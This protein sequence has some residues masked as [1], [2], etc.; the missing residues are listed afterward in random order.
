MEFKPFFAGLIS[1]LISSIGFAQICGTDYFLE[2]EYAKNPSFQNTVEQNWMIS[3]LPI[4]QTEG[5][6]AVSIIPVVF[7]VFH[8]N[9]KGN[10]SYAQ[11][12]SAMKMINNDFRRTNPDTGNTRAIFAPF[13]ADSEV[14]FRLARIDPDGNCTNGVVRINNGNA[15]NNAGNNVKSLSYW[16]SNQYFNIWVVNTIES[17][18]VN[19]I[20]LGYA[21]FPG[22]GSWNTYGVVIR[23]DRVGSIGTAAAQD[24]TLTHEIGH[25]LNLLHTFQSGCGSNCESSGDR[26]CDTPPVNSSTQPCATSQNQCSNDTQG[27][28]VYTTDVFDQIENYMSYNDCQNMFSLGQKSRMQNTL[29]NVSTLS[30]LTSSTN[31]QNT[32][33]NLNIT[34]ICNVD[35]ESATQVACVGEPLQFTDLSYFNP[36]SF[37]W[38]FPGGY[39]ATSNN[40]N[41]QV[42]YTTPGKYAVKLTVRDSLNMSMSETKT[43]YITV[44]S[45]EGTTAP[46][47][48]SFE[49]ANPLDSM[50]WYSEQI[51]TGFAWQKST[52]AG[53]TGF[54]A[55]K[56][57]TYNFTGKAT[58][59][60]AAYDVSNLSS[61]LVSFHYAYAPKSNSGTCYLR[62]F[63]SSD[64]GA[65]WKLKWITGGPSMSTAPTTSG[66]YNYPNQNEWV[67]A[68]FSVSGND[69]GDDL[70]IKFEFRGANGNNLFIDEI[71]LNGLFSE[72]VVL[73][74]PSDNSVGLSSSTLLNWKATS[75]A[76]YYVLQIDTNALFNS[77]KL[78]EHQ[79]QYLSSNS[80]GS[81]SEY[82]TSGLMNGTYFWR[83]RTVTDTNFTKWTKPWNFTVNVNGIE[84][85]INSSIALNVYPNPASGIVNIDM[86]S[87][88]PQEVEIA[89]YD[90]TGNLVKL[91][92]TGNVNS[93]LRHFQ[94]TSQELS[95]GI[96]LIRT[97]TGNQLKT[98]KLI[99]Q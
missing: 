51:S 58:I 33:A 16:P 97:K 28:S 7:H 74:S 99:L 22:S 88:T 32:G 52:T 9:G 78:Q 75:T 90:V 64:C 41:P 27:N 48:E 29:G 73:H 8:E 40:Q 76:D 69:L 91:I 36:D 30:Q 84:N 79:I 46:F 13:A 12:E 11:I 98:T 18:G 10:I 21:Q 57:N 80:N 68:S 44:I 17:S 19:G 38:E 14:E 86:Q 60:S 96:Y 89:L 49:S 37:S 3:D 6:R 43:Q 85:P 4:Q 35:F 65:T 31:L 56:S 72:D 83:V 94:F 92:F 82:L 93:G 55:I 5:A 2:K 63:T 42:V 81:D 59:T 50:R 62:A 70:R 1:I 95:S 87:N 45:S 39:P 66:P 15:S 20:I 54:N 67:K 61:A 26:V 47:T 71:N 34:G 24:R 23:N 53:Y 77:P 25:C